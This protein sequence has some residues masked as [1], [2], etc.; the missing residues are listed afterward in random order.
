MTERTTFIPY[1]NSAETSIDYLLG[2]IEDAR[3]TT[4]QRVYDLSLEELH[5]Q[6]DEGWNTIGALLSHIIS[7]AHV[8]RIE[9]IEEREMT[10]QESDLYVPGLE[11]GKFIPQLITNQT[12]EDYALLLAES[13]TLLIEQIQ[14]LS[15]ED[16]FKK[17]DGYN[18]KTGYNLAW[19]LYHLAEDEVHHRGQISIV[20]KLFKKAKGDGTI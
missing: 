19:V 6:Y 3:T 12:A 15:K 11:M 10:K 4:L 17:R 5:W 7:S 20:R 16:F 13:K 1:G 14:K 9:F 18:P 2:I 8:F